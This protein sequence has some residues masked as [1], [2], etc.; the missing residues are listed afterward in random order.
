MF[1]QLMAALSNQTWLSDAFSRPLAVALMVGGLLIIAGGLYAV[2]R[3]YLV[4]LIEHLISKTR[5]Q[6]DDAFMNSG[7]VRRVVRLLPLLLLYV[8]VERLLIPH[9]S[10]VMISR[11]VY[12]ALIL[13]V[14]KI[15]QALLVSLEQVYLM[16]DKENRRSVRG[17]VQ[18]ISIVLYLFVTIFIIATLLNKSPWGL[19]SVLGGLTAVILLVFKD[20]ILGFVA[21]I[22]LSA[23]DMVRVG[24]WV[25]MPKYG[26]DG[27]V[28]DVT[29]NTVKIQNWDKTISTI[30]TYAMISDSFK[31]WRGMSDSGGRRI[32]R[33]INLD[34]NSIHFVD[35][36]LLERLKQVDFLAEYIETK[37]TEIDASNEKGG[38]NLS[39]ELNGR[40]QTNAG[41]FR[42]YLQKYLRSNPQVHDSMTFLVRQ[43]QPTSQGLPIEIYVFSRDQVW[44]NYESIQADI[45][46]HILAA[47]PQFDLRVFQEPSGADFRSLTENG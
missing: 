19:F 23:H 47:I 25:E 6:W 16:V 39:M 2:L 43:L 15:I 14:A 28:I 42:A 24:D 44:A 22:Q 36:A 45:F 4:R 34:M 3:N 35:E 7:L 38:V 29:V 5:N 32:K 26:A 33:S 17:Y 27:D 12:S 41:I 11:I 9:G 30:P 18:G 8:G 37:Q 13:S 46:D 40:R 1:E 20:T 21:G 31:N 10:G